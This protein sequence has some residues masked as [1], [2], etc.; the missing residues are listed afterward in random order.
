MRMVYSTLTVTVVRYPSKNDRVEITIMREVKIP[1]KSTSHLSLQV[2]IDGLKIN[3]D[4]KSKIVLTKE[5]QGR[6]ADAK[7]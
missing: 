6:P 2:I 5:I 3:N 7:L 1:R 4:F